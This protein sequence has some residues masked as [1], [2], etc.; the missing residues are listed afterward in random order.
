MRWRIKFLFSLHFF[1]VVFIELPWYLHVISLNSQE[2]LYT[3]KLLDEKKFLL[4]HQILIGFYACQF[5]Y[6]MAHMLSG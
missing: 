2:I 4:N 1:I 3:N 6:A 5:A